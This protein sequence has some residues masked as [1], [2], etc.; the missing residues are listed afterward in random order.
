MQDIVMML[1]GA[2]LSMSK[3][4]LLDDSSEGDNEAL[5]ETDRA[6]DQLEIAMRRVLL[7]WGETKKNYKQIV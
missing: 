3:N 6:L 7:K 1:D 4:Y 5:Q 2:N